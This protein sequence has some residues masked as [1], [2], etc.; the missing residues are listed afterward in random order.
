MAQTTTTAR[1]HALAS[2]APPT[3]EPRALAAAPG[4]AL[5]VHDFGDDAGAGT[6]GAS[7]NEQIVPFLRMMQKGSPQVDSDASEYLPD[8]RLGAIYD[9]GSGELF[10]GRTGVDLLVAA[11]DFHFGLWVPRERGGGFRGT[12]P[13]TDP[14]VQDTLVRLGEKYGKSARFKMPRFKQGRWSDLPPLTADGEEVELVETGQLVTV[15]AGADQLSDATARR[16]IVACTSTSLATYR[17]WFSRHNSAQYRQ[18]DGSMSAAAT[19]SYRWNLSTAREENA[20]GVYYVWRLALRPN[21][22]KFVE[23]LLKRTDP[24]YQTAREFYHEW[25]GGRVK[26]D[27]EAGAARGTDDDPPF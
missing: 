8:A 5:E 10:D 14:I 23:A 26:V 16:A 18:N 13:E 24:L 17:G 3:E 7:V 15:Y 27:Y 22:A 4:T 6:E 11:R 1:A 2:A 9:T 20:A 25:R 21:G 12:V 19:F